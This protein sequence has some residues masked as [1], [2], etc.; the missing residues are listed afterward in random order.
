MCRTNRRIRRLPQARL[1]RGTS[2]AIVGADNLNVRSV[3]L[4]RR[5]REG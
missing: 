2:R 1:V 4:D 3:D 5:F